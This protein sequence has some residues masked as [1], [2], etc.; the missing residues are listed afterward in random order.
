GL[1]VKADYLPLLQSLASFGWRLTCVL[2]TPIIKRNSDGSL[3]TKQIVF[4][5]RPVLPRKKK[6]SKKVI[7]KTRNKSNKNSVKDVPKNKKKKESRSAAEKE[8]HEQ[9]ACGR[10]ERS[11]GDAVEQPGNKL[12]NE[13]TDETKQKQ[14]ETETATGSEVGGSREKQEVVGGSR[15]RGGVAMNEFECREGF[16]VTAETESGLS[17]DNKHTEDNQHEPPANQQ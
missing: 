2:P 6:D 17:K 16:D 12:N 3:A 1:E 13:S 11:H 4:L 10:A 9:K 7:F 14:E 8:I 15:K 5:Q